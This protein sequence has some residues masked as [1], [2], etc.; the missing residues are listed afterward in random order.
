MAMVN[1]KVGTQAKYD[2]ATKNDNTLYFISDAKRIYKGTVDV[3]ESLVLV[4]NYEGTEGGISLA[5]AFEGKLYMNATTFEVRIKSGSAWKVFSPGYLT[6]GTNFANAANEGRLA[7]I[8]AIKTYIAAQIATITGGTTFVQSVTFDSTNKAL[9]VDNGDTNPTSVAL[10]GMAY[11][12]TYDSTNLTLT[13]PVVGGSDVVVNIP[14]DNFVRSGRYEASYT[15]PDSSTGPA[16]V[17][18][19]NNGTQ[20]SDQEVVIPAASLID[21]Y[22]G[23]STNN[24]QVSVSNGNVITASVVLDPDTNNALTSS[25]SGLKVDITGKA[26]KIATPTAGDLVTT[27]ANGHPVDSGKV[28]GGS[29]LASTPNANTVATEVAVDTAITNATSSKANKLT[30]SASTHVLVGS[31]AGDLAD[32]GKTIGG[33]TLAASPDGNTLATEAAVSAAVTSGVADK[34]NKLTSAAETHVLVGSSAGDLA[35]SGKTILSSGS[36]GNSSSTIP[37]ANLIATELGTKADKL[38]SSAS[39][40]ILVGAADGNIADS[41]KTIGGATLAASPTANTVA[42][43]A[44]VSAAITSAISWETID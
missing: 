14:K 8:G 19:V 12:P 15:L 39:A 9:L 2:A 18:V 20:G 11:A 40:H 33:S 32:S 16:I 26:N 44:A 5:N 35:D 10:T 3:T 23:G 28:V 42:T 17:L 27:D 29:T 25:A 41:S 24:V 6:D 4:S 7:T 31:S 1:F 21:V 38:T 22:T 34:A 30:A 36:M 13:I 43:E 37:T